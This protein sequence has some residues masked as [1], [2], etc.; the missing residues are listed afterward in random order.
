MF[1]GTPC[2]IVGLYSY[3]NKEYDNL[4][5]QDII[6]H[7]VPSPIVWNNYL[8]YQ[9]NQHNKAGFNS[10]SFRSKDIDWERFS[11][12]LEF[13]NGEKYS[14]ALTSDY[15]MQAFLNNFCLRPSCYACSFK[16]KVSKSDFTLAD[17]WG[18][19]NA[20]PEMYSEKGVSL[21]LLN[22]KRAIDLFE[23]IKSNITFKQVELEPTLKSNPS[24]TK[25]VAIPKE[26]KVFINYVK[27]HG[28]KSSYDKYLKKSFF[29][30]LEIKLKV[31]VSKLL[32]R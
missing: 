27:N 2:Q 15:Y 3:L 22:S 6:C 23:K 21:V 13:S 32:K 25:S 16:T 14:R 9:S 18:I 20:M 11:M 5:T 24:I 1:T 29:K 30:K 7:G 8:E 28:I 26:R 10:I 17:F 19:K 12:S 4:I 31:L